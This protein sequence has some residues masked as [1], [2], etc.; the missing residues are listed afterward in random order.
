MKISNNEI[1]NII[2]M[3][4]T[5][6][7]KQ[8]ACVYNVSQVTIHN[9]IVKNKII[10]K[11]RSRLNCSKLKFDINY[12][13][14][15]DNGKKAYWLGFIAADGCLKNNKLRIIS[16]DKEIPLKFKS[17]ISSEHKV[18]ENIYYDKRT[19]KYYTSYIISITNCLFTKKLEKYINIDKSDK[20]II[21]EI[22]YKYYSY[23][24]A[25]LFDGDGH[26]GLKLG[27]LRISLLSTKECLN[28]IQ[29]ILL[30]IG[31]K[32]TKL[33]NYSKNLYKMHLYSQSC[34]FL[35][36]IYNDEN[37]NIYLERKYKTYKKYKDEKI[38]TFS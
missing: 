18:C 35:D 7:Q 12:F 2:K 21:P 15:I 23:F 28:Q 20:F 16:K 30:N 10:N 9:F 19:K 26:V 25:G 22:E 27:K 29:E 17:D 36:F 5:M 13:D 31:I 24:I 37:S 6:T 4:E 34:E 8:I 1:E 33:Y 11:K 3:M 14:I 38:Y 32:K